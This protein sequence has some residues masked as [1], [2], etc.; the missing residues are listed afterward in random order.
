MPHSITK[1]INSASIDTNVKGLILLQVSALSGT[2]Y[3]SSIVGT[4]VNDG[5]DEKEHEM[6][7]PLH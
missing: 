6:K 4:A 5:G 2:C 7:L 3:H 1:R